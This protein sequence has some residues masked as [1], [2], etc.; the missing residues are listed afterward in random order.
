MRVGG[1]LKLIEDLLFELLSWLLSISKTFLMAVRPGRVQRCIS[2][3]WV[4]EKE[5]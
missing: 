2:S 3:E 4:S 1:I 5:E